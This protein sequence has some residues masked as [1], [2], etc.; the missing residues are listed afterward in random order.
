[1]AGFFLWIIN[2][3]NFAEYGVLCENYFL[4]FFFH[5]HSD[6]FFEYA[7]TCMK[8]AHA[9]TYV[10]VLRWRCWSTFQRKVFCQTPKDP[11]Q[12][13]CHLK[14]LQQPTK[15]LSLLLWQ[16]RQH[17]YQKHSQTLVC[18]LNFLQFVVTKISWRY[19]APECKTPTQSSPSLGLIGLTK[20]IYSSVK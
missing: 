1:M 10:L 16:Q 15:R 4:K 11:F 3:T 20:F 2:F 12:T 17:T 8:N 18:M 5:A 14:V 6:L 13:T 7:H 9:H 19:G